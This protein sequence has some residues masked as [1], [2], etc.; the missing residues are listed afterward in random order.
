MKKYLHS[1][2]HS[3]MKYFLQLS[4]CSNAIE[5]RTAYFELQSADT[6]AEDNYGVFELASRNHK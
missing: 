1:L 5:I 4:F 3:Q 2:N 6:R